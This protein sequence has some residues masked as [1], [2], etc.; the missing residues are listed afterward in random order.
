MLLRLITL[1]YVRKHKL[2]FAL[3]TLGIVFGVGVFVGMHTA[4]Q[5]V[6]SAFHQTIDRIA[7]STQLQ[8]SAGEPGFDEEVLDKVRDVPHI[9]AAAPVIEASATTDY[10][11]LLILGVDMLG[12]RALRDYDFEDSSDGIDDPLVF[13][14]QPDSL[15]V[16]RSFAE[17]HALKVGS[18]VPM[19]TM[20]GDQVFTVRGLMKSGGLASA[21]GGNLAVMDIY[22]A[23]KMFGRGRKFDRVDIALE[24]DARLADVQPV[25]QKLLGDG[26]AVEPPSSRGAQFEATSRTYSLASDIT[27]VFA[28]FIGMFLIYNTFSIAA[29][30]RR[31]E[32]GILRALGATRTQIR[33]L[34]LAESAVTGTI[35][36]IAGIGFGLVLARGMAAYISSFLSDIYG[37]A[38]NTDSIALKPWVFAAALTIGITTSILAGVFPAMRAAGVDPVRA[39]QKGREQEVGQRESSL[40]KMV[41]GLCFVLAVVVLFFAHI[42]IV[43]YSGFVLAAGGMVLMAPAFSTWLAR[44]LRPALSRLLPVEGTLAVD[45]LIQSPRRT[46]GTVAALMLSL[47]LT[48]ALSGLNQASYDSIREWMRIALNPD[49]FV[50]TNENLTTRSFVFPASLGE[51]LRKM[52]GIAEVQF[53]R[54]VRVTVKGSPVMLVALDVQSVANRAQL[55]ALEGEPKSMYAQTAGGTGVMVSENFSRLR[56]GHV[57]E[58]LEVPAPEGVLRLPIV[59]VVRDYSDQQG[60][61]LISRDLFIKYWHDDAVNLFRIYLAR[62]AKEADVRQQILDVYGKERRLFVLTN[63]DVRRY[64]LNLADQWLGLTYIQ[65]AV[66]VLV[67]IL[68]IVNALTVSITDRRRELGVLQAVGGL[69]RQIRGT[70][71]I[72]AGAIGLVG[73]VLGFVLGAALQYYTLGFARRELIGMD[74]PYSYPVQTALLLIP[75][76][77]ASAWISA[78]LPAESAVRASLVEAL[79][80]E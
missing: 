13:L 1:P 35:G 6:L 32:I 15:I 49:L 80:Y 3:T 45:S 48:I 34:F 61:V 22:S 73:L 8:V 71:W 72:E 51:G 11:N 69:R 23:Q 70:I 56:G 79:E 17:Q 44:A 38:Q 50:T 76:I 37:V 52:P 2:R 42:G 7:G 12:D 58:I 47:A 40:R 74:L 65:V 53:V 20:A 60:T 26:F 24:E 75:V 27:S 62:G 59:G 14:A 66:A 31:K 19:R 36:T 57:G 4:N 43:F 41:A 67:A 10:G 29:A 16:A 39:L 64:I 54:S 68:G 55:P 78:I 77:L 21:F 18:K 28:L 63:T 5:S 25:I 9:R 46:S 33:D 30:Q